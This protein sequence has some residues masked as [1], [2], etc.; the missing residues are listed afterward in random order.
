M[1]KATEMKKLQQKFTMLCRQQQQHTNNFEE[2]QVEVERVTCI[3]Q[4]VHHKVGEVAESVGNIMS[5]HII[6]DLVD[7]LK[8]IEEEVRQEEERVTKILQDFQ[9]KVGTSE[10][11][12]E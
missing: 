4:H 8:K 1:S 3:I 10:Q 6:S 11:M 9:R 7:K 2:L 5:K 12:E